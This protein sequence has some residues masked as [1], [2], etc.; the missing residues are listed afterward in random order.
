MS[1]EDYRLWM[2]HPLTL[3][4]LH[5]LKLDGFSLLSLFHHF[6][7]S[8]LTELQF[9]DYREE[10]RDSELLSMVGTDTLFPV[11]HEM[12]LD[13]SLHHYEFVIALSRNYPTLHSIQTTCLDAIPQLLYDRSTD[14][15]PKLRILRIG[16]DRYRYRPQPLISIPD[17]AATDV[18]E[19]VNRYMSDTSIELP[20]RVVL[21]CAFGETWTRRSRELAKEHP[22][23]VSVDSV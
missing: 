18:C 19:I 23:Q 11:F 3:D 6:I 10:M 20:I 17:K 8:N 5:S 12:V 14:F 7:A 15:C 1:S 4:R 2:E 13:L 16:S 21:Y 22:Y 9:K